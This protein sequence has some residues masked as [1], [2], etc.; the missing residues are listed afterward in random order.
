MSDRPEMV[1][2]GP[3]DIGKLTIGEF[4]EI[5]IESN[6][7]GRLEEIRKLWPGPTDMFPSARRDKCWGRSRDDVQFLLKQIDCLQ[8]EVGL[9]E[10]MKA[11]VG[12]RI[13]DL[14]A[15]RDR[16]KAEVESLRGQVIELKGEQK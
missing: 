9:Y 7:A 4:N 2:I 5:K 15:D 1:E 11:G 10:A 14:E 6:A 16:F 13:E 8:T 3:S 12:E